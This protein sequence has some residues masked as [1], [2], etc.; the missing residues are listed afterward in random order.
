MIRHILCA[1]TFL[2]ILP[3][4]HAA[5]KD[6]RVF[7]I[8]VYNSAPGRQAD[9]NKLIATSGVKFM[10]KHQIEFLGAWVPADAKDERVITLVAHKDKA[11]AVKNWAAFREDEGWKSELAAASTQGKAVAGFTQLFL[12][13]TDFSPAIKPANVGNRVFELRTYEAA[14]GKL[15]GLD[16]RFRDHTLKLFDKHGMT[17]IAYF[18]FAPG[19]KTTTAEMHKS[20]AP[21]GKTASESAVPATETGLV[22]FITHP[23]AEAMKANFGKFVAD[24]AWKQ[25]RAASERDGSL[26]AKNG[27]ISLLLKPTDY[28]PWK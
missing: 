7:E 4:A 17:N 23:S 9:V 26:T 2:A 25:A 19:E 10:A 22:Y 15:A 14:P 27:V 18:H 8:R 24:D 6:S 28:S 5:E 11:A 16:S 1:L 21:M 20:L 12:T 13:P 3:A